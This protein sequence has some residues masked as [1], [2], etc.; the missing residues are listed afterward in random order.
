MFK[1]SHQKNDI[2]ISLICHDGLTTDCEFPQR[3]WHVREQTRYFNCTN[4]NRSRQLF[5]LVGYGHCMRQFYTKVDGNPN[6]ESVSNPLLFK[7]ND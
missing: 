6:K 1:D 7:T 3:Y 2:N 5:Y 4:S